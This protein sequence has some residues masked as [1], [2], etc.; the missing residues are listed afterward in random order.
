MAERI[1]PRT[2]NGKTYYYLQRTWREKIDP[3]AKGKTR[4][5][6]KSRVRTEK[7]YLGSAASI[8]KKMKEN[9]HQAIEVRH[10]SFGFVT[11]IYQTAIEMGLVDIL[12]AHFSGTCYGVA[13]WLYFMLPIINRLESA[14]SKEK[15]GKWSAATVLP[16]LLKFD[17][18]RLNS[19]SFWYA[20]D[21][22]MCERDLRDKRRENPELEESLFVGLEDQLFNKI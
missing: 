19:N 2:V 17:S 7:I 4:G 18:N 21:E 15:M 5:S 16:T 13:H 20:T 12:K 22:F 1:Y 10:R 14:T 8:H 3:N 6:G 11:A 9:P